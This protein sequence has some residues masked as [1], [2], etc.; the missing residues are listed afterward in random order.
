MYLELSLNNVDILY[1]LLM[2][3]NIIMVLGLIKLKGGKK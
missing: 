1:I 2:I 3:F